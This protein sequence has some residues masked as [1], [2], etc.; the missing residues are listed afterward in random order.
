MCTSLAEAHPS[1]ERKM[2][3][4]RRPG[5]R[6]LNIE[7]CTTTPIHHSTDFTLLSINPR[8]KQTLKC[9]SRCTSRRGVFAPSRTVAVSLPTCVTSRRICTKPHR[10]GVVTSLRHVAAYLHQAAPQTTVVSFHFHVRPTQHVKWTAKIHVDWIHKY[11]II[12]ADYHNLI[13]RLMKR[14]IY[15]S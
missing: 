1:H 9:R 8:H 13:I 14:N 15:F 6:N 7:S 3:I 11:Y 5:M 2:S 4:E 12:T 10:S